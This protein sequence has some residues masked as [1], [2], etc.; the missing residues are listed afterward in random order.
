MLEQ[1]RLDGSSINGYVQ[2]EST[3]AAIA[4]CVASGIADV[5][6]GVEAAARQF[7][8]DFVPLVTEDYFFVC[9]KQLLET[10]A[11]KRV[12]MIIRDE[13]FQSSLGELPGYRPSD[14]GEIKMVR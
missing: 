13:Q 10:E 4:A 14:A 9:K 3:H 12:L 7:G 11:M 1:Q 2:V 8:L 5:G 6:F